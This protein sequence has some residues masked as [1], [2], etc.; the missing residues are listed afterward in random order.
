MAEHGPIGCLLFA[1]RY[2]DLDAEWAAASHPG[3]SAEIHV[4]AK[5]ERSCAGEMAASQRKHLE[6]RV[7]RPSPHP[8]DPAQRVI[9]NGADS[10][11]RCRFDK[12]GIADDPGANS[13][14]FLL[15]QFVQ[16]IGCIAAT[17]A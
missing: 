11:V 1:A 17:A 9:D 3:H 6:W 14:R 5:V 12:S 7:Q 8:A 10:R 15:K 2:H 13:L 4:T 16:E